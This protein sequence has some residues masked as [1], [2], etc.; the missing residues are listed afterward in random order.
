MRTGF[1][2]CAP[3]LSA[4]RIAAPLLL[5]ATT[6][7]AGPSAMAMPV[8]TGLV[9]NATVDYDSD[10]YSTLVGG[11]TQG[12]NMSVTDGGTS[13]PST[14]SNGT[15]TPDT[16]I[17]RQLSETGDGT[18]INLSL[19]GEGQSERVA[20]NI[21]DHLF[22]L[23]NTSASD[24]YT[25]GLRV[26]IE[27]SADATGSQTN[28]NES[29]YVVSNFRLCDSARPDCSTEL[30]YSALA[31]DSYHGDSV[32]DTDPGTNGAALSDSG[33]L[34]FTFVLNPGDMLNLWGEMVL[35]GSNGSSADGF[36]FNASLTSSITLESVS[37]TDGNGGGGTV[38]EPAAALLVS[39]G[40][41]L[42]GWQ[43]R[44]RRH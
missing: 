42:L 1:E 28:E 15:A 7:F 18:S 33:D 20:Y 13:S 43:R 11:V 35:E 6:L 29:A 5:A 27:N 38:P 3:A 23:S 36:S 31:S 16:T 21:A 8:P 9:I 30:M 41:G 32:G 4:R 25:V 14:I 26:V 19:L 39:L 17:T 10:G 12:G 2:W 44:S 40:L 34:L 22:A 24:I 37:V